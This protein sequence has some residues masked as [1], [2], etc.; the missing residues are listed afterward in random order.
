[1][2]YRILTED[3]N[4]EGIINIV[5]KHF[6]GF[7]LIPT[8]GYWEGTKENSLI[9]EINIPLDRNSFMI[10]VVANQIKVLNQQQAVLV[11]KINME[12]DLI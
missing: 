10:L 2:L 6:D 3:K 11:Q 9:I 8:I 1:M 5:K 12:S 7:T 4:R